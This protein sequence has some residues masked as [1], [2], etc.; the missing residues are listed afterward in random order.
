MLKTL[1]KWDSRVVFASVILVMCFALMHPMGIAI[2]PSPDTIKVYDLVNSLPPG[3]II[4][5]GM[6][7]TPAAVP[8]K[9]PSVISMIRQGW[10]R[11]LRFVAVGVDSQMAGDLTDQAFNQVLPEF[12]DK[13]YGVDWVNIGYKPGYEVLLQR[14]LVSMVDACMNTDAHGNKLD[15]MPIMK[16][17][18]TIKQAGLLTT[19]YSGETPSKYVKHIAEPYHIPL[20][21]C[22]GTGGVPTVMPLVASG[23]VAGVL[24]GMKGAA[25]YE[26]LVHKPGNATRG[27][28][29]QSLVHL[30]VIAFV[31][32]GNI[33]YYANK[34]GQP[35]SGKAGRS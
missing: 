27:L 5:L 8:E 28:D 30:L 3:S 6:D 35:A 12:P 20:V 1:D 15:S 11:G 16:D 9:E 23:Q 2:I 18:Q 22:P 19:F 34:K 4:F 24:V 17:F 14:M 29:A 7:Y 25:E 31:I 21:V 10:S 32:I 33:G 26:Q 13:K